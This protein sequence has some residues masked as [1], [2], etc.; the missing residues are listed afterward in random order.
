MSVELIGNWIPKGVIATLLWRR[1]A[2]MG[3]RLDRIEGKVDSQCEHIAHIEG[4][5]EGH[6]AASGD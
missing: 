1:T 5:L 2:S 6:S 4:L 3:L